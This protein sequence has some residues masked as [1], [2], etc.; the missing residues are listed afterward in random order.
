[1]TPWVYVQNTA[2]TANSYNIQVDIQPK[3]E[4]T[5]YTGACWPTDIIAA[6]ETKVE[7][8]WGCK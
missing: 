3:N 7:W 8:P 2:E 6:G 1:L 4:D 5:W